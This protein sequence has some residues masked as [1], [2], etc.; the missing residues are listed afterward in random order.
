[1]A[2]FVQLAG[3]A[4]W[5][6]ENRNP[7]GGWGMVPGQ[8][9]SMVNTA[10]ALY[11]LQRAGAPTSD[12]APSIEYMKGSLDEHLRDRGKRVRYVALPL[13]TLA[14]C[15]PNTERRFQRKA[16]E[17]LVRAR[18]ADQ[19]WGE[20]ERNGQSDIFSTYLAASALNAA[21]W[22][23]AKD[24]TAAADWMLREHSAEGWSLHAQQSYSATATAY[25]V[26]VLAMAG[27]SDRPSYQQGRE[28]LLA[29]DSWD[30]E[31]VVIAG[32]K[33][34]HS[35]PTA[36]IRALVQSET[37][38]L[39]PT[40]AEAV[41]SFQ[42]RITPEGW[43]EKESENTPTIRSQYWATYGLDPIIRHFDPSIVIP[44][45][46]AMR[47]Q[48]ALQEPLFL[49]FATGTRFHTILPAPLFRLATWGAAL[50]GLFAAFGLQEAI[51]APNQSV[52]SWAGIA[53][54][55]ASL[56]LMS[57]RPT[58]FPAM[59]PWARR[60]LLMISLLGVLYDVDPTEV[61]EALKRLFSKLLES[62]YGLF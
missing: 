57:K 59:G 11:V 43:T 15:F 47:Q 23:R 19:G 61:V 5:L 3:A 6:L 26:A 13:L 4:K 48:G 50:T 53:L 10:E 41:R 20:V 40:V 55:A 36:I 9:S 17:W 27:L 18:N 30:N 7:D 51:P 45:I 56:Y 46:D 54:L 44:R 24:V 2:Y 29:N 31:E 60:L 25:A 58:H 21:A 38:I 62:A 42:R 1:M 35:K 28:L 32:T 52:V 49:P 8:P 14:E 33:W 37:D 22:N 16:A 34:L 12:C 39:H